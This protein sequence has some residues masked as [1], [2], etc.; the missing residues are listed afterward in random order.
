MMEKVTV[1][2]K[3]EILETGH[4]QVRRATYLVEDGV[5]TLLGYHRSAYTPGSADMAQED[6]QVKAHAEMAWTPEVITAYAETRAPKDDNGTG[7]PIGDVL[8]TVTP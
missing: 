1:I 7:L 2:D 3:I 8:G 6:D 4:I 5:R